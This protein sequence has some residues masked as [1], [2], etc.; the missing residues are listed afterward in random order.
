M[1]SG[2]CR[3]HWV[4]SST[5]AAHDLVPHT[6]WPLTRT[7]EFFSDS[8]SLSELGYKQVRGRPWRC[9]RPERGHLAPLVLSERATSLHTAREAPAPWRWFAHRG[10][11][12]LSVVPTRVV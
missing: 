6:S 1:S 3:A 2:A 12:T 5:P 4:H 7:L 10:C 11:T 9:G 8:N